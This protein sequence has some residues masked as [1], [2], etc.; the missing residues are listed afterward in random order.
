MDADAPA[1]DAQ[2]VERPLGREIGFASVEESSFFGLGDLL[3]QLGKGPGVEESLAVA[4]VVQLGPTEREYTILEIRAIELH[5]RKS[6]RGPFEM[7]AGFREG[8]DRLP[9]KEQVAIF[10]DG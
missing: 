10:V 1:F 8:D 3:A 6:G 7:L 4:P 9:I 5:V 2:C